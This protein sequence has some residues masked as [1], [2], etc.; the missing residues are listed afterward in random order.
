MNWGGTQYAIE[1]W[2]G[3]EDGKEFM[4]G[5]IPPPMMKFPIMRNAAFVSEI[6]E[7]TANVEV[8]YVEYEYAG[9]KSFLGVGRPIYVYRFKGMG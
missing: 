6:P 2:G 3:P 8:S 5:D 1:L 4:I 7:K 9:H